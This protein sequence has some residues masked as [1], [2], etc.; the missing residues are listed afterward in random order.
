MVIMI[1]CVHNIVLEVRIQPNIK[2]S[3]GSM[4]MC[5]DASVQSLSDKRRHQNHV[6]QAAV[7][8]IDQSK[9]DLSMEK[10]APTRRCSQHFGNK[11]DYL[12]AYPC[13]S[14]RYR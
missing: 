5:P 9:E 6:K 10:V 12:Y 8:P 4:D 7:L 13:S 3:P 11:I 1:L 14:P 2:I